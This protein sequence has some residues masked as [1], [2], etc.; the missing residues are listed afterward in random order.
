MHLGRMACPRNINRET[1]MSDMSAFTIGL[2]TEVS[3]RYV[4]NLEATFSVPPRDLFNTASG[5]TV[6]TECHS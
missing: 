1:T 3:Y 5:Y 6:P 4:W 2:H